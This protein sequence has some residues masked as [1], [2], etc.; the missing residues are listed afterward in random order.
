MRDWDAVKVAE[1]LTAGKY[2]G[3]LHELLDKLTMDQ[4][5]DLLLVLGGSQYERRG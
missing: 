3:N 2:N 4:L 1:D 5:Q